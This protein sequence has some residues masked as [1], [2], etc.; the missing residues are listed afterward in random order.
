ML[1]AGYLQM[2]TFPKM[3]SLLADLWEKTSRCGKSRIHFW[4]GNYDATVTQELGL[5][6][7]LLPMK[8]NS[9]ENFLSVVRHS[10]MSAILSLTKSRKNR[11]DS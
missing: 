8:G 6:P 1:G 2:T 5:G 4:I 10:R 9:L 11:H 3:K 7:T